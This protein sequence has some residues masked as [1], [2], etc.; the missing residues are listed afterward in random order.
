MDILCSRLSLSHKI[1]KETELYKELHDIV[2]EA[3]KKLKKE[4]GPL[5]KVSAVMARGIVNRLA[6]GA[7]V[8]KLCASA[9][10]TLDT[11]LS[12]TFN[13]S[14]GTAHSK[15]PGKM[16]SF[17]LCALRIITTPK[18][19]LSFVSVLPVA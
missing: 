3:V 17:C 13:A 18:I 12:G 10:E 7:E 6:C 16:D 4:L 1:L 2:S 11:L 14:G 9:V 15:I 5:D 8:Q 19:L